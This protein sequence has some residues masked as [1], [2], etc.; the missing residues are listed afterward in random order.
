MRKT[1]VVAGNVCRNVKPDVY[2][3]VFSQSGQLG[4]G[5]TLA[6]GR[7]RMTSR[8]SKLTFISTIDWAIASE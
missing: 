7:Y 5:Y 1:T 6:D 2:D 3:Y 4:A 8:Q